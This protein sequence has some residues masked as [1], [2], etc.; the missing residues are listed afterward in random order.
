MWAIYV[1]YVVCMFVYLKSSCSIRRVPPALD[2]AAPRLRPVF[3]GLTHRAPA[4]LPKAYVPCSQRKTLFALLLAEPAT[5]CWD[6]YP[7]SSSR[8]ESKV[9][10]VILEHPPFRSLGTSPGLHRPA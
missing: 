1:D 7:E 2:P 6:V 3:D 9:L 10:A 8:V 5:F 4:P